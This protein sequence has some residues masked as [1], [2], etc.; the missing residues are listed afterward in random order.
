MN[1]LGRDPRACIEVLDAYLDSVRALEVALG[2]EP[3]ATRSPGHAS[4]LRRLEFQLSVDA[5]ARE[6]A[7]A[8]LRMTSCEARI[9]APAL[10]GALRDVERIDREADAAARVRLL[11]SSRRILESA[12]RRIARVDARCRREHPAVPAAS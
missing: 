10:A 4:A 3:G 8:R 9:L 5:L 1:S 6:G 12:Q 7:Q 11:S 2:A